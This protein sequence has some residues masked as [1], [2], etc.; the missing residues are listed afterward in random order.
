[1]GRFTTELRKRGAY[2]YG[3][4]ALGVSTDASDWDWALPYDIK[5]ADWLFKCG[6]ILDGGDGR[7]PGSVQRRYYSI[8]RLARPAFHKPITEL[9]GFSGEIMKSYRKGKTNVVLFTPLAFA[10]NKYATEM[11]ACYGAGHPA[12]STKE[13]RVEAYQRFAKEYLSLYGVTS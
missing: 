12:V 7:Y 9:P 8:G 10:A 5:N 1:M 6:F 4:R 11:G 3:S 13:A 2:L